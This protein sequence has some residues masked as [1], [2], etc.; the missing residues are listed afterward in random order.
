MYR[1]KKLDHCYL[2]PKKLVYSYLEQEKCESL[3]LGSLKKAISSHKN[4][5]T[6]IW[7][8]KKMRLSYLEMENTD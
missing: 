8:T 6:A 3:L 5:I 7:S 2:E 1:L 4:W